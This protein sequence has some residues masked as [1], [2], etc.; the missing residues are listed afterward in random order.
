ML[1]LLKKT[2]VALGGVSTS[3]KNHKDEFIE[4]LMHQ[5]PGEKIA[6]LENGG[7]WVEFIELGDYEFMDVH[8]VGFEK[9]KT[10]DGAE[11]QFKVGTKELGKLQSDTKEIESHHSNVS[12]RYLTTVN[13]EITN[14][15]LDF[16]F[17]READTV[18]FI[19]KNKEEIF[20]IIQ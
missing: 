12:N 16:L 14:L 6:E 8:I 5:I 7:I 20:K 10:Y 19:C 4:T 1:N 11:L 17:D 3:Q 15:N 9:Y 2:V 18:A 13:F